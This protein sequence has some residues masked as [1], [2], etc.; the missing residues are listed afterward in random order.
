[1]GA[2]EYLLK[3]VTREELLEVLSRLSATHPRPESL[4]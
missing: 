1:M 4:A 2:E 3:P